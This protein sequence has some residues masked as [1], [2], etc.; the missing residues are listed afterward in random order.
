MKRF[1]I[2]FIGLILLMGC[3]TIYDEDILGN[4]GTN[5]ITLDGITFGWEITSDKIIVEIEAPTTG[6]V[7]IGFEPSQ[8]MADAN[9]LIGNVIDGVTSI[10]DDFGNS[11]YSHVSDLSLGGEDNITFISGLEVGNKTNLKF[12]IPLDSGDQYDTII[13]AG[14]L[15]TIILAFGDEDNLDSIHSSRTSGTV[16]L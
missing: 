4:D 16:Q 7:S 8:G 10:R 9:I 11:A 15:I 6:W 2:C 12:S 3:N 14:D 5:K 13:S 1:A